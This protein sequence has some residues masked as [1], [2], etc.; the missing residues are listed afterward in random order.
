MKGLTEMIIISSQK[1]SQFIGNV[2]YGTSITKK[3]CEIRKCP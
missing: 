3:K 1:N 2:V